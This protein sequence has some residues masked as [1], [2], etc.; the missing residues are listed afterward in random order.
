MYFFLLFFFRLQPHSPTTCPAEMFSTFF[1]LDS[2]DTEA[3]SKKKKHAQHKITSTTILVFFPFFIF[4]LQIHFLQPS[5]QF[6]RAFERASCLQTKLS[7]F[8][9]FKVRFHRSRK[10]HPKAGRNL[11]IFFFF[12]K[13]TKFCPLGDT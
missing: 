9:H 10:Q 12:E 7:S 1:L 6:R 11:F 2:L 8:V 13:G 5:R 3:N 4:F